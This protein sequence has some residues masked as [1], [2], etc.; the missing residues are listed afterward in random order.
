MLEYAVVAGDQ[1]CEGGDGQEGEGQ[2]D[3]LFEEF[4]HGDPCSRVLIVIV[5]GAAGAQRISSPA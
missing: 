5:G 2:E 3:G 4:G 1:Q